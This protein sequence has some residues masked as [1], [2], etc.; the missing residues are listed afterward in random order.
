MKCAV[1]VG[2]GSM[3]R[4]RIRIVKSLVPGIEIVCVDQNPERVQAA[5]NDG[6]IGVSSIEESFQYEPEL[7]FVCTS[8]GHHAEIILELVGHGISVFTELNLIP[9]KYDDILEA[10]KENNVKV[11]MSSTMLYDRQVR[12]IIDVIKGVKEPLCYIYHIGQ[13]LP[14]WHPWESYKNFFIGRKETNGIREIY[15]IQLPWIVKAFGKVKHVSSL[16]Q[17]QTELEIDYKDS[18][19]ASFQH[20]TGNHGVFVA[21]VVARDAVQYLEVI[22]EHVYIK[23]NGQP[24]GLVSFDKEKGEMKN[25]LTYEHSEHIEGYASNIYENE[26]VDEV[27]AFLDFVENGKEPLYTLEDDKYIL[28]LIDDIGA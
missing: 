15:A 4:R 6:Y 8:P 18:F 7:G 16:A 13:Y 22:G 17:K 20:E 3:G 14:D 10:A 11:F 2:Y 9:D 19:I 24:D 21:D 26:Y 23:W 25:L 12:S 28:S 27:Q 5:K 1:I